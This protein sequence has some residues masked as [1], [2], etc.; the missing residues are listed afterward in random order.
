LGLRK[1]LPA[2]FRTL[3]SSATRIFGPDDAL[4][5]AAALRN[6][7]GLPPRDGQRIVPIS[8]LTTQREPFVWPTLLELAEES[9]N[10][11]NPVERWNRPRPEEIPPPFREALPVPP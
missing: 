1:T 4:D 6:L 8:P 10:L 5:R 3:T 2:F 11:E 7:L 9:F